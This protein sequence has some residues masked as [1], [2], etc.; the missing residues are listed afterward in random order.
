MELEGPYQNHHSAHLPPSILICPS[1]VKR[2]GKDMYNLKMFLPANH[3]FTELLKPYSSKK[4]SLTTLNH[5]QLLSPS[6]SS[7]YSYSYS[8]L[9]LFFPL[10]WSALAPIDQKTCF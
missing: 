4:S 2:E 8:F 10:L 5:T 9:F 6:S 7:P 3:C 1:E